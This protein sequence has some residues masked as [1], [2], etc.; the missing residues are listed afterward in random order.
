MLTI[1][2]AIPAGASPVS[3]PEDESSP[4]PAPTAPAK[5]KGKRR[6]RTPVFSGF[7][8]PL[9]K[10][11]TEPVPKP[12]GHLKIY[13][14]NWREGVDVSLYNEDGSFNE[15]AVDQLTHLFRCKK[16][17][18]ERP[19]D[20]HLFEILSTVQDHF[21]GRTLHLVSG[22]RN[23]EK[24]GSYHFH[25]TA[26]DLQVPGISNKE[27]HAYVASLDTGN[28]GLGIYPRS[29]FIHVDIRPDRSYRWVDYSAPGTPNMGH[30]HPKK[31]LVAKLR[32]T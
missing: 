3:S 5:K 11:R 19:I 16:S 27:L 30:P 20:P 12:S 24:T 9:S 2:F 10:I 4:P 21:K 26:S 6:A 7:Q 14:V 28:M 8:V 23:T 15:D 22:F 13:S 29:G 18:T 31:K 25:G 1:S 17:G 32:N